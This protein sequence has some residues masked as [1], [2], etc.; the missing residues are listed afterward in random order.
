MSSPQETLRRVIVPTNANTPS[1]RISQPVNVKWFGATGDGVTDDTAAIQAALNTGLNVYIPGTTAYYKV[2]VTLALTAPGQKVF[3]D[4][5]MSYIVQTGINANST[6]IYAPGL[7]YNHFNNLRVTPGTTTGSTYDGYG[8]KFASSDNCSASNCYVTGARRGGIALFD[9]DY[10]KI[11]NN[12]IRDSVV[13]PGA[14]VYASATGFDIYLG[15]A[16]SRNLVSGNHCINGCGMGVAVQTLAS[17]DVSNHNIISNNVI[18]N[19]DLYGIMLYLGNAADSILYTVIEGN[20]IDTVTGDISQD[21]P[22]PGGLFNYGAGIYVQTALYTTI[23]GNQIRNTNVHTP[24]DVQQAPAAIGI[25]N[26]AGVVI[27]S[28]TIENANYHGIFCIYGA[29][30]FTPALGRGAIIANNSIWKSSVSGI[31]LQDWPSANV[32]NNRIYG[33]AAGSRGVHGIRILSASFT[34]SEDFIVG[35][36]RIEHCTSGLFVEGTITRL[37]ANGNIVRDSETYGIYSSAAYTETNNNVVIGVSGSTGM[38]FLGTA[39]EGFCLNNRVEV[40]T[41]I[42]IQMNAPGAV[43]I[44]PN[45]NTMTAS[46]GYNISGVANNY[47]RVLGAVANPSVRNALYVSQANAGGITNF[48]DGKQ[49]QRLILKALAV[50]TITDGAT[51][52]VAGSAN[53]VMASGDQ[54]EGYLDGTVWRETG[55]SVN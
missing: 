55:R 11:L 12:V 33:D 40:G 51:I 34:Q 54:W 26:S 19:Q 18:E 48:D 10:C 43:F 36:N 22:P 21:P 20:T 23:T 15:G 47:F 14:G 28:N 42:G 7:G 44:D 49:G 2:S 29:P 31:V 3:G 1:A 6:G 32:E 35:S 45:Q 27:T 37:V 5:Y 39:L 17:G 30:A 9:C 25:S 13:V 53:F 50:V 52:S 46:G 24:Q 4:G 8:F 41:G 38:V 16:C